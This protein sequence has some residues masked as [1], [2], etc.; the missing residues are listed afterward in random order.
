MTVPIARLAATRFADAEMPV[1]L[2]YL[3]SAY[4]AVRPQRGQM[5]EFTQAGVELIGASAPQ[6][7]AEVIEVLEAALAAAGLERA[8]IGLGDSDLYRQLLTEYGRRGRGAGHDPRAAGDPRPRRPRGRALSRRRHLRRAG[9][10]PA[11]P[12]RNFAAGVRSSTRRGSSAAP[13]SS[14][15]RRESARPSRSSSGAGR[16]TGSAST[17]ACSATSATTAARSSRS[18]TPRSA[19]CSA[20]AAATTACCSASALDQPAAGFALYVERVHVAQIER[21]R[22]RRGA[23]RDRRPGRRRPN[24]HRRAAEAGGAARRAARGHPRPARCRRASTPPRSA[25]SRGR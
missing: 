14:G 20:A 12:S 7:T 10:R 13:R 16:R 11:S 22:A 5:R 2:C 1:R 3:A 23:G 9:A 17:S 15:R 24:P 4:R 25:A 21:S 19:T 8:V 6:G 18:T